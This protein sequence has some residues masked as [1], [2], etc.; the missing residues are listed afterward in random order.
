MRARQCQMWSE[1][2]MRKVIRFLAQAPGEHGQEILVAAVIVIVL[3][4]SATAASQTSEDRSPEIGKVKFLETL[5]NQA[6][7]E[8]DIRALGDMVPDS[9][10][11]VDI[12]GTLKSKSEFLE[13][14]KTSPE[15]P[16]EIRNESMLAHAYG[17]TVVVTGIYREKGVGSGKFYARRGRFTDTWVKAN[18]TWQCVASQLT[19]MQ[20]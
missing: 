1:E 10:T 17:N 16:S 18:N 4:L 14:L 15:K 9:F 6:E 3:T 13:S 7:V 20:K 11:Y 5:W 8:Q 2:N 19:L 12:D